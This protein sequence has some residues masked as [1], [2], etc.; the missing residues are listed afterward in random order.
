MGS[1]TA[2]FKSADDALLLGKANQSDLTAE[3]ATRAAADTANATAITT[4]A[5][6][7]RAA[8]GA[9]TAAIVTE[10][11][12]RSTAVSAEAAARTA[13]DALLL[14]KAGGTMSGPIAMG[15]NKVTGLANGTVATDGAAFGQ[16][17]LNLPPSGSAGGDITG[18]YPNPTLATTAVSAGSYTNANITV[19]AKGRVTAAANGVALASSSL[20]IILTGGAVYHLYD[21]GSVS[22]FQFGVGSMVASP[23]PVDKSCTADRIG[24]S[25]T[26]GGSA[27][28]LVRLG[29]YADANGRPGA[30]VLDAGTIDGTSATYQELTI[31]AALSPGMYWLAAVCQVAFCTWRVS[32]GL[33]FGSKI[34]TN[35][36]NLIQFGHVGFTQSS[37]TGGLP[38]PFVPITNDGNPAG[39]LIPRIVLRIT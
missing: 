20:Q 23:F 10:V 34:T 26:T 24:M 12:A 28:A 33:T 38:N 14:P 7:A 17:P 32:A 35:P 18:T 36:A 19:D 22:T 3:A 4:E 21:S 5:A 15:A 27:G 2:Y 30:L 29:I 25:V 6:T 39:Q 31:S 11:S 16:I 1:A 13:A 37:V 8:E 9:N